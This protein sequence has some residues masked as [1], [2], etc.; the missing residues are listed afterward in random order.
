MIVLIDGP[1]NTGKTTLAREFE[2][3]GFR[4]E[5]H[6]VPPPHVNLFAQYAW[7]LADAAMQPADAVIDRLH[8]AEW[9]YGRVMRGEARLTAPQMTTLHR[10]LQD[11]DGVLVMC[12]TRSEEIIRR[13]RER[14]AQEYVQDEE[15]VRAIIKEYDLLE[16]AV[17]MTF[18]PGRLHFYDFAEH[19]NRAGD[20]ADKIIRREGQR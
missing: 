20:F 12:N 5:H 17:L 14:R 15:K 1:D 2:R 10:L 3:R 4:Y 8:P 13:W 18:G 9:A 6:S 7:I 19:I 16:R 11:L